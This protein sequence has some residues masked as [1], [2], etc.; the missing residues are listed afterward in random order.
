LKLPEDTGSFHSWTQATV[1]EI[2][3]PKAGLNLLTLKYNKGSNL[4][5]F[6]FLLVEPAGPIL[7][8]QH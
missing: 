1:G 8:V 4:A 5:Y 7:R 2:V 6:D 3:F